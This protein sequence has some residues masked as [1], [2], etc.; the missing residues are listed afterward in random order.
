MKKLFALLIALFAVT[1]CS[2]NA[3]AQH[4]SPRFGT[5]PNQDKTFRNLTN[6]YHV[7]ADTAGSTKDT[8]RITPRVFSN[9]VVVTVK[10]SCVLGIYSVGDAFVGDRLTVTLQN[11]SGSNHFVEFL[12]VSGLS[13]Y[14]GMSSTGTK[15]SLTSAKSATL[16]FYFDGALWNEVSR[17]IR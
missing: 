6:G 1:V 4:T 2:Y 9:N 14:W 11:T 16:T 5:A 3:N 17:S 13:S 8:L 10:D 7:I 15:I 12:N